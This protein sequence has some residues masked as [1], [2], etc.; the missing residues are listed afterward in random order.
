MAQQ[1]DIVIK[2]TD[3][4]TVVVKKNFDNLS[5]SVDKADRATATLEKTL[6]SLRNVMYTFGSVFFLN[7]LRQYADQW[8]AVQNR[9][10][11]FT[12]SLEEAKAVH[13]ELFK[14]VQDSRQEMDPL[15]N[16]YSRGAQAAKTLGASQMDLVNF[17]EAVA[18]S[19]SIQGVST[20]AARG[21]LIQL[22]QALGMAKLRAQEF[23]SINEQA[24]IILQ[25]VAKEL[26]GVNGTVATM[27]QE[28]LDGKVRSKEFFDAFLKG[29]PA[30]RKQFELV[31][32]T[33][34]QG[35]TVMQNAIGRYIGMVDQANGIS[36]TIAK[37]M[38]FVADN[39]DNIA[40]SLIILTPLL[41]AAFGPSIAGMINAVS[42]AMLRLNAALLRNPLGALAVAITTAIVA[43]TAFRNE[44]VLVE[45]EVD[46]LK[47]TADQGVQIDITLGDYMSAFGQLYDDMTG[48]P[49][50]ISQWWEDSTIQ[51]S[52]SWNYMI[53]NIESAWTDF[54]QFGKDQ[55][56][57]VARAFQ[58][59]VAAIQYY[60]MA[61]CTYIERTFIAAVNSVL[62]GVNEII[63]ALNAIGS[64]IN[65]PEI[66]EIKIGLDASQYD[67]GLKQL[68]TDYENT[69][70]DIMSSDLFA[71][72]DGSGPK[73]GV[74]KDAKNWIDQFT[75]NVKGFKQ[76]LDAQAVIENI[77][78]RGDPSAKGVDL[79]NRPTAIPQ[80]DAGSNGK[81]EAAAAKKLQSELENLL[82]T[83]DPIKFALIEMKKAEDTLNKAWAAGSIT[84]AE[85]DRYLA[86]LPDKFEKAAKPYEYM[87]KQAQKERSVYQQAIPDQE[88]YSTV[89]EQITQLKEQGVTVNE[90][91]IQSLWE[92]A[93][94]SEA[95]AQ[96]NNRLKDYYE[97][98]PE[99]QM[100][101]LGYD[102]AAAT[103]AFEAGWLSAEKYK[104]SLANIAIE[105]GKIKI[106]SGEISADAFFTGA[107]SGV[108]E[109]YTTLMEG[110]QESFSTFYSQM[111]DG[112]A[113]SIGQA[114]VYGENLQDSLV[115]LS[116]TIVS[117]LIASLIKLGIQYVVNA[118]LA[119]T[120]GAASTAASA[121]MATATATAWA[122]AA[123]MVSLA[124]FG[125]NAVPANV[126][127]ASTVG[128][129]Q[130]MAAFGGAGFM[131][132]GY[133][134]DVGVRDVAG[135][136]H[137]QEYV[138]DAA[139]TN[140]IGVD[141][142]D[143]LRRG[144]TSGITTSS[145][146]ASQSSGG[147]NMNVIIEN[148]GS[149]KQFET[150]VMDEQTVRIIA[151]DV[152]KDVVDQEAGNAT[153]RDMQNP[154][155][156]VSR[157]TTSQ[158]T[159]SRKR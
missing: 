119:N 49:Y 74:D 144:D 33:I 60:W 3:D 36:A 124:S 121:T 93:R 75:D 66:S 94:A 130:T 72:T 89:L 142:L 129:A 55:T 42:L 105:M 143:A 14:V 29:L 4:G 106:A 52:A 69:R 147:L 108:L 44:I 97:S 148:Y 16:L 83:L 115:N 78:R 127:I 21:A 87:I 45:D 30:I 61:M 122:P 111:A 132:G 13:Q 88:T 120:V 10:R 153:A 67:A 53:D 71:G 8:T 24:P 107:M 156:R 145:S 35:I 150:Q 34:G 140:R 85:R 1:E 48:G 50:S 80:P 23:N 82:K 17:T 79:T 56:N 101:Q 136:V 59:A 141:N 5:S 68:K 96:V 125:A 91:M 20:T 62:G 19:L 90:K 46:N 31:N 154:N 43:L 86:M 92:E 134:G 73:I 102:L 133:T 128:F 54:V 41:Y 139:A 100:Q 98:S 135:V 81:K 110:V 116:K 76:S 152:A 95:L 2:V 118:A 57:D 58:L 104:N 70:K 109:N 159:T 7:E 84:L 25:T 149:D 113:N 32:P 138:F 51:M 112:F 117:Q 28:M 126:G 131:N 22:G 77:M 18:K 146:N 64:R 155:S 65:L 123:A 158:F 151:R 137:G 11:V 15:V 9:I 63:G 38:I 27:R 47:R 40:K 6:R 39:I 157:A 103:Q 26:Y 12:S 114:I 37:T 99:N